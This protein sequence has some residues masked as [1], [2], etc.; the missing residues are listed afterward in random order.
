MRCRQA[1]IFRDFSIRGRLCCTASDLSADRGAN[2]MVLWQT[3]CLLCV[4][5]ARQDCWFCWWRMERPALHLHESPCMP[6]S[7]IAP[8]QGQEWSSHRFSPQRRPIVILTASL[9]MRRPQA[10]IGK[11]KIHS[12]PWTAL[13]ASSF[14]LSISDVALCNM[15][16]QS[17]TTIGASQALCEAW[18]GPRV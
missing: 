17:R 6:L 1:G 8:P 18:R 16:W 15:V 12:L 5:H 2:L 4:V 9:L 7:S 10:E 14:A 3:E 11:A 13:T